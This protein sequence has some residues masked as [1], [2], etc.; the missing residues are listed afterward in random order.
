[1]KRTWYATVAAAALLAWAVVAF[2][3]TGGAPASK[4][5]ASA[6]SSVGAEGLCTDCHGGNA[7]NDAGSIAVV[8]APALYRAGSTYRL[9]V[10]LASTHAFGANSVWGFQLTA[11]DQASGAGSGTFALV[12]TAETKLVTGSGS[13]SAR[14]YV[15]QAS[16]GVRGGA[17]SP[18]EW[19]VDWTAPTGAAS[20]VTFFASGLVSDGSGTGNSWVYHASAASVD[21][22][23]AAIPRTWGSIKA[24][25]AR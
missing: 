3:R 18:V 7:V 5:G 17:A 21:T 19:Q 4:T 20:G 15:D 25:Y 22:V 10:H 12:N 6:V 8:G 14:R 1:M 11:V 24:Q 23:T 16:G 9:T 2:A 13:F